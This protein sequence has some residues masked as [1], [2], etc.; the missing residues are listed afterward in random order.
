MPVT[1][2]PWLRPSR[3]V[4]TVVVLAFLALSSITVLLRSVHGEVR[5]RRVE[6]HVA[7]GDLLVSR[8]ELEQAA[9]QYRAA[10]QL[11]RDHTEAGRALALTLL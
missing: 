8:G 7:R 6:A 10:L 2:L 1:Y 5:D 9:D 3:L 11:E 4:L